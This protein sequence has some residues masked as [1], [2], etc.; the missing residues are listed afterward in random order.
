MRSQNV[1]ILNEWVAEIVKWH[2]SES[3]G[4]KFWLNK[5]KELSFNPLKDI[6]CYEDLR[7]FPDYSDELRNV[8]VEDLIPA[9]FIKNGVIPDIYESGGATGKPKRIIEVETRL[10]GIEWINSVLCQ[11]DFPQGN[12]CGA[13]LFIGPTGPHI[14][15]R[16]MGRLAKLRGSVCFFIDFDPRWV[17]KCIK[18]G[19][20]EMA[21]IYVEHIIDEVRDIM[22][23]QNIGVVFA[24]PTILERLVNDVQLLEI[25]KRKVQGLIWSGTSFSPESIRFLQ[26]DVLDKTKIVGLY[27]NTLMG[28][29][30][31]RP[32]KKG[33]QYPVVF[34]SFFPYSITEVVD[35]K[36][37]TKQ[38]NYGETGQVK[39]TLL[40][41][42]M[43][44][45]NNLERDEAKR[46]APVDEFFTWD[47]V[48]EVRPAT[49]VKGAIIE[50]VY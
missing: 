3:S 11:H 38:V 24:T 44:I 15:G 33:A 30:G 32:T 7:S 6:K 16:S 13:W 28:I 21:N 40:T 5:A 22:C 31:Q 10:K 17:R 43:F 29:A 47:G 2:F 50:G 26:E 37:S 39:I 35:F 45:P 34:H 41:K 1:K 8:P 23:N 20:T 12:E 48:S 14:V 4:S 18:N 46:I 36:D 49:G 25:M 19:Q 42:E 9:G 27:G